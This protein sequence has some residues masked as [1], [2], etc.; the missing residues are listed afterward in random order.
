MSLTLA[1][2]RARAASITDVSYDVHLDLSD[3][4]GDRYRSRTA[5]RFTSAVEETLL[6]LATAAGLLV[7]VGGRSVN[8]AYDGEWIT[9]TDLPVGEP[10]EVVV[11][12]TL[13][14]VT[15]GE[16]MHRFT[17]PADG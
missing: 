2:A 11:T 6:E 13:P 15:S 14:Y 10:V 16:A 4:R 1:E 12:A 5:V 9:L 3:V 7:E 17:D 8:A